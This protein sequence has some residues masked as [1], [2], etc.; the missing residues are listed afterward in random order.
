MQAT[1]PGAGLGGLRFR[2]ST[3]VDLENKTDR[4]DACASGITPP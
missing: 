1:S 3:P 4:S 2:S